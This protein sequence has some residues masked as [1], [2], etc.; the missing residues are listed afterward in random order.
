MRLI[1][2]MEGGV[3]RVGAVES[4]KLRVLDEY[5]S[6]RALALAAISAAQPLAGVVADC[7]TRAERAYPDFLQSAAIRLLPPLDHPD[8]AHY[9]LTGT[10]LTHLGGASARDR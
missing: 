9:L 1:Q 4:G 8:P 6:T 10:G 5:D 2:F 7:P 3:R